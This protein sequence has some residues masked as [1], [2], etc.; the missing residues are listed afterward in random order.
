MR[1]HSLHAQMC[2][3]THIYIYI[4]IHMSIDVRNYSCI[5]ISISIVYVFLY[6]IYIYIY[7]YLFICLY[8]CKQMSICISHPCR[9]MQRPPGQSSRPCLPA[10]EPQESPVLHATPTWH[11]YSL[12]PDHESR[13]ELRTKGVPNVIGT[14]VCILGSRA[15]FRV[16]LYTEYKMGPTRH[17][18]CSV[19]QPSPLPPPNG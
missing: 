1:W 13:F 19:D 16:V 3:H 12:S 10:Y 2:V 6:V 11:S 14:T 8:T 4:Y 9:F 18:W 17:I 5:Y 15:M 7:T